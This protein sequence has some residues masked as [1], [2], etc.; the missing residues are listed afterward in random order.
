MAELKRN[1][2]KA[3]MNKDSDERVIPPGEYLHALNVQVHTSDTGDVGALQNIMGTTEINSVTGGG[4]YADANAVCVGIV[5]HM[6]TDKIYYLINS[7]VGAIKKDYILEYNT[8]TSEIAYVF[9]DIYSVEITGLSGTGNTFEVTAAEAKAIRPGMTFQSSGVQ[10]IVT[11][12]DGLVVT[13]DA[14]VSLT[15]PLIL[16]HRRVLEFPRSGL[17]TGIN[18]LDDTL[19]WTDNATEPKRVNI[20]RSIRG[21][22]GA[23]AIPATLPSGD[24]ADYHTRFIQVEAGTSD[25]LE[26]LSYTNGSDYP[27]YMALGDITVIRKAPSQALKVDAYSTTESEGERTDPVIG[28]VNSTVIWA[29]SHPVGSNIEG[30]TFTFGVD[31][32]AGDIVH[33]TAL[34]GVTASDASFSIKTQV[35]DSS[36][37]TYVEGDNAHTTGY[38]FKVLS[39]SAG[40]ISTINDWSVEL[41]SRD[42]FLDDKF[43]RFSYRYKYQDGEYST[44]APWSKIAFI[45]GRYNYAP[46]DGYNQGMANRVRS[47]TIKDYVSA[48]IPYGVTDIDLLYKETNNPT[49]YTVKTVKPEDTEYKMKTD[50]VHALVPSNQLLRPWDNVPRVAL[51]QEISAN[52]VIYGNYLQ[53]YDINKEPKVTVGIT[54]DSVDYTAGLSGT[55]SAK[56]LRQYQIGVVFSDEYGRETPVLTND[57]ASYKVPIELSAM[58]NKLLVNLEDSSSI[59]T[60]AKYYSFYVKEPT[61]EY[62][63]LAMDRWYNAADGNIWIS[64]PS[65]ERN[66]LDE[67]TFLYLKKGHGNNIP[68][69]SGIEYKILAIEDEAP[70]FIKILYRDV[71][72]VTNA[73]DD[74]GNIGTEESGYP[75]IG[76]RTISMFSTG[77][78]FSIN[79]TNADDLLTSSW[80]LRFLDT[81]N[82]STTVSRFYDVEKVT[83]SGNRIFFHLHG[84]ISNDLEF[85][86]TSG[87]P[88][89]WDNRIDTLRMEVYKGV[90]KSRPEFDGRF[91]AKIAKDIDITNFVTSFEGDDWLVFDSQNISYINNNCYTSTTSSQPRSHVAGSSPTDWVG[92]D[93]D[94]TRP[95]HP[96]EHANSLGGGSSYVWNDPNITAV[97]IQANTH[98]ALSKDGEGQRRFWGNVDTFF[99]DR[100]SAYSW[101]GRDK[102][103]PGNVYDDNGVYASGIWYDSYN[104][105]DSAEYSLDDF[106]PEVGGLWLWD[107]TGVTEQT[108]WMTNV[109]DIDSKA[110]GLP[111]RGIWSEGAWGYMDLS[112]TGFSNN[113]NDG[114]NA[115]NYIDGSA[116]NS[117][118]NQVTRIAYDPDLSGSSGKADFIE[119][120]YRP[121]AKFRFKLDPDNSVYTV[122]TNMNFAG[123][124]SISGNYSNYNENVWPN[125]A[126]S[127][128]SYYLSS[129][130][131][132]GHYGIR[133]MASSDSAGQW[134]LDNL[135]QRWTV[136][137]SPKFGLGPSGYIPTTGTQNAGAGITSTRALHHDGTN[138]DAIEILVPSTVDDDGNDISGGFVSN[139]AVWETKP[140]ESVDIDIYYQASDIIPINLNPN[141]DEELIPTNSTFKR[142]TVTHK[143]T[144]WDK[145]KMAITP[146]L[147]STGAFTDELIKITTPSGRIS[148]FTFSGA[149]DGTFVTIVNSGIAYAPHTLAWNNCWSFGN[150]VE[151]D[152]VRDDYNAPQMDNGVKASTVLGEQVREERRKHGL[153][154]SGIY[155]STSGIN[156]TNQFIQAE[157]ITKDLNPSY[158]SLQALLNRDT[159][160]IMFCEDKVLRGVTNKDALYNAD[161]NPQLVASNTVVG[162]VTP[163]ALDYGISKNP[164]SLAVSPS[165]SYFADANRGKVLALSGEGIVP[166]S[167]IGMEGHFLNLK[168]Y[169]K[170]SS[171]IV[172]TF[173]DKT[174]E[175]NLSVHGGDTVSFSERGRAWVSFKSFEPQAGIS[176]NNEYYT[177]AKGGLWKHHSNAIRNNFYGTQYTS[178]VTTVFGDTSG[179]VK[180]FNTVNYE[181]SQ[182]KVTAFN[183]IDDVLYL[184]NDYTTT[185][186][187]ASTDDVND[188][189]YFNLTAKNGWYMSSIKTD[190]Q[191]GGGVEF[192]EKEGKWF[193]IPSGDSSVS[194]MANFSTQGLGVAVA[195]HDGTSTG[196]IIVTV[197]NS[198]T[199]DNGEAWD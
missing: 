154:W 107:G 20:K 36:A 88:N 97:D 42:A 17:V 133:N 10:V 4:T 68:V 45:P 194:S 123:S 75:L 167:D 29:G 182:A 70:D 157:K 160:L 106:A 197:T 193:G 98:T 30:L 122:H 52:R 53:N 67:E 8:L 140:K 2:L 82:A 177:F 156:E 137:V 172:G 171:T 164:E 21:T 37:S 101:S 103:L 16:N 141:T 189:E 128:G 195:S 120:L 139:P 113:S 142:G 84:S 6:S 161:G 179:K 143:V 44:F 24:N 170:S 54:S 187:L 39:I 79:E 77:S 86:T 173:D 135:R 69:T 126:V 28:H 127:V 12:V 47:L 153:I 14:A 23:T 198:A 158:G 5:S 48:N 9:V 65:S 131:R 73:S 104:V 99:I 165:N 162:D 129:V 11:K 186:G 185:E 51:A 111:S 78:S 114:V 125:Q 134:Q 89:T 130:Y 190:L 146:S 138:F 19:F 1:F 59:P 121:G 169:L 43:A 72:N 49:V 155:N 80:R 199:G 180:S 50:M 71:G 96:T 191:T 136:K 117:P 55:S 38:V 83:T 176:L 63:T 108:R 18:V 61:V 58:S 112:W 56:S 132:H 149:N 87:Q 100:S 159:R 181:G 15:N 32:R 57:E 118:A 91:F 102:H 74:N 105:E 124:N 110:M 27:R 33:F 192:R 116:D 148:S 31:F 3:K 115:G 95:N 175:Y 64:F 168:S 144:G 34:N 183:D 60:W 93:D 92:D 119:K 174:R 22:G 90:V 166:I 41:E 62:Y 35:Q 40:L 46:K 25:V 109:N 81:E 150:G 66:K 184:N 13:L 188:G 196:H 178:T 26:I 76:S 7:N 85:A 145:L 152:R 147:A 163:Y 151:S 94:S